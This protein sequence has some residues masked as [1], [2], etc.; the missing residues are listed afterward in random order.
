MRTLAQIYAHDPPLEAG[1]IRKNFEGTRLFKL[2][3]E[4]NHKV[5]RIDGTHSDHPGWFC[6][7]VMTGEEV[8]VYDEDIALDEPLNEM[9]VM[10]WA[11]K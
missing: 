5:P 6:I 10:A 3:A 4:F 11:A 2:L 1:Q 9:E 8:P 7:D